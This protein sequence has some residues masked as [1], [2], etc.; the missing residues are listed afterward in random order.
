MRRSRRRE[1]AV[2]ACRGRIQH[3]RECDEQANREHGPLR[4]P[5]DPE[6]TVSLPTAWPIHCDTYGPSTRR[7]AMSAKPMTSARTI[8]RAM[9][10]R[11]TKPRLSS[12]R[13]ATLS[14]H[15][16]VCAAPVS[17]QRARIRPTATSAMPVPWFSVSRVRLSSM[18]EIASA[19]TTLCKRSTT[20][21]TALGP[22]ARLKTPA[23]TS[24]ADGI[25][26]KQ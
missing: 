15:I 14:A 1:I 10:R 17:D 11:R 24:R 5:P 7:T 23:H 26:R 3:R 9:S 6:T 4:R 20:V 12:R 21:C 2:E 25:A 18:S 16:T 8:A 13:C 22:A 19:G